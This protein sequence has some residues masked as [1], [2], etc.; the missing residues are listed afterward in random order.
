MKIKKVFA[1]ILAAVIAVSSV[2]V[3]AF[4]EENDKVKAAAAES[5]KE[6]ED[7]VQDMFERSD[8]IVGDV[9]GIT[10]AE[11]LHDL[12]VMFNM[13]VE[14]N[15]IP[16]NYF[17]DLDDTSQYYEDVLTATQFG[18][19]D[20][21]AGGEVRPD[22]PAEREFASQTL[23]FC[24]GFDQT[25]ITEYTFSDYGNCTYPAA[26]QIA[27]DRG[28]FTLD[29]GAFVPEKTI[30]SDEIQVMVDDT[31]EILASEVVNGNYEC[32]YIFADDVIE[33]PDGT[34]VTVE[35]GTVRITECPVT[36]S[37]GAK[38]A[39]YQ[40]GIPTVYTA[41]TVSTEDSVTTITTEAVEDD[42]AFVGIDAQDVIPADM[43]QIVP[44]DGVEVTYEES[45]TSRTTASNSSVQTYA[46]SSIEYQDV[47]FDKTVPLVDG[48]S[49]GLKV[50]MNNPTVYYRT[51]TESGEAMVYLES[52]VEISYSLS[53][54]LAES[55]DIGTIPIAYWGIKG[56]GGVNINVKLNLGGSA[57]GTN[58]AKLTVGLAYNKDS[59]VRLIR[60]FYSKNF[61][62]SAQLNASAALEVKAGLTEMPI[63][64]AYVFAE[65]G[66]KAQIDSKTY[67]DGEKPEECSNFFAY[68]YVKYGAKGGVKFAWINKP[69][70]L[71]DNVYDVTNSPVRISRHYEDKKEVP[72]CTRNKSHETE[73][74]KNGYVTPST[75]NYADSGL[76]YAE[77]NGNEGGES[78]GIITSGEDDYSFTIDKYGYATITSYK[79]TDTS[80]AVPSYVI[81]NDESYP[82]IKISSAFS[83][84]EFLESVTIPGTVRIISGTFRNCKRLKSV[85]LPD[86]LLEI[87]SSTFS[88]CVSLETISIPGNVELIG[89]YAFNE[90]T[91]LNNVSIP[92]S[93]MTID[94][95]AFYGC[96]KLI[97]ASLG[98]GVKSLG[99]L[100]FSGC[101]ELSNVIMGNRLKTIGN[102]AFSNCTALPE[103]VVPGN[104]ETIGESAFY[105]CSSLTKVTL[106]DSLK[107]IGKKAFY[108]CTELSNVVMGN[109]VETIGYYA[110]H[111]CG[112]LEEITLPDS[113]ISIGGYAFVNTG[114]KEIIVP[115]RVEKV[116][117]STFQGCEKLERAVIGNGAIFS[118]EE[119]TVSNI[120]DGCT[121]LRSVV[122]GNSVTE[123]PNNM[124][125]GFKYL[126]NVQLGSGIKT[127]GNNAFSNC[128][129]LP[130]IVVPGNV[131]TIGESVFY[132]CSSLTKVILSDSLKTIGKN[133]FW[134]CTELTNV[135]MGN[136]VETIGY[137][138]FH[139]CGKLEEITLPD[140]LISI[141]GYAFVNAGLKEIIVPDRVE[142]VMGSA[143]Q[144]CE[145]LERAVI[146]NGAIFS[147]EE[148]T[149]S[150]IFDGCTNLRSV[151]IGNSVTEIP[152]SMF[153]NL[154]Y[155]T[156][157]QLGSGIKTIGKNAFYNCTALPEIV[158][159]G[160]VETIGE[161]AFYNCSS[162]TKVTL[163]DSLKT[164][165]KNAF[166][167]CTELT[168]VVMGNSV[169]T[170]EYYAFHDCGKLEE[171]TLPGSLINIG[172]YAFVNT[173]L[174]EI[175]LPAN[176]SSVGNSAFYGCS[177]LGAITIE[178][179]VCDIYDSANTITS[180]T[181]IYGYL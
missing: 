74:V 56:I 109:S 177:S 81:R 37:E 133:A 157:V 73:Y 33:V 158:V 41:V 66:G 79:G 35:D 64:K 53:S 49:V 90:C 127:I 52:D 149:I 39:V 168:N 100:S 178:N 111:D 179:T 172:G 174:K 135:V 4:A 164:I 146:G 70:D 69:F 160:N 141:G 102:N 22:E 86:S 72:A 180:S 24:L 167:M 110:F 162:L 143:F 94:D 29:S 140:S 47:S 55:V 151:V 108:K 82:V 62:L 7:I 101:T 134:M 25:G 175:V 98:N 76:S 130:E 6:Q 5:E 43:N 128:T 145:K 129:A 169:E 150:N 59:G 163:P 136:S 36:V 96:T 13:T 40:N 89:T 99:K 8:L 116:M 23:S 45:S 1:C 154:K 165:G 121:N 137:Y 9:D 85:S 60:N 166:W 97:S 28:W 159:P 38:F 118:S 117:G 113:L 142:K 14:D 170:I 171:I 68:L 173:G 131:E 34:E 15:N 78:G 18:V 11:W 103:I 19:V 148:G 106:P 176:V 71:T 50:R 80:L 48:V 112:K 83:G 161:S 67:N 107:T 114:L 26:A 144:D 104:V 54:N 92:D 32:S 147:S 105:N 153:S 88:G 155:L 119:G 17:S 21:L 77:D 132:N 156:D 75:S 16:D 46:D 84:N 95:S 152:N 10:R 125:S 30:T 124:F 3:T 12:V 42:A 57:A 93:V 123:I 2:S 51:N 181:I 87:N 58:K 20:V 27:L 115:D 91:G 122:I 63:L 138:A 120:F 44:A 65:A 31:N 126:T 61:S 139:D